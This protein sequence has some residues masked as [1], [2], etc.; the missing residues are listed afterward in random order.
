MDRWWF[1][2]EAVDCNE[3]AIAAQNWVYASSIEQAQYRFR[4]NLKELGC[5]DIHVYFQRVE[6]C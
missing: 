3:V 6:I 2:Y 5:S 4:K 1:R